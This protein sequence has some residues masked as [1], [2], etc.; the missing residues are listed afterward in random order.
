MKKNSVHIIVVILCIAFLSCSKDDNPNGQYKLE[1]KWMYMQ[2][3]GIFDGE[4]RL[5]DW[6][7]QTGC[8]VDYIYFKDG[9]EFNIVTHD[10]S[11][12]NC[13]VRKIVAMW[14]RNGNK[15][16][17]DYYEL[18]EIET[19]NILTLNDSELKVIFDSEE[20]SIFVFKRIP[21]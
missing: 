13:D 20:E 11:N 21:N 7:H 3:G 1:G 9:G 12:G 18:N 5:Y 10:I 2:Y 19:C 4:E 17:I 8:P 14:N 6:W 15:I 16:T